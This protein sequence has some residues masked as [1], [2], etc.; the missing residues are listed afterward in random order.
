MNL[1]WDAPNN[2]Q[3]ATLRPNLVQYN[4]NYRSYATEKNLPLLNHFQNWEKLLKSDPAK[5]QLWVPDG[6]HPSPEGSLSIT[7]P[8]VKTFLLKSQAAAKK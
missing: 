4:A 6:T 8:E 2:N 5:Y 3:S 7:W 1:P